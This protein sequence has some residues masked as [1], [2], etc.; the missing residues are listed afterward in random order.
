MKNYKKSQFL[1]NFIL[2]SLTTLI[3]CS[4]V[5]YSFLFPSINILFSVSIPNIPSF[6]FTAKFLFFL[7]NGI[8][9]ILIRESKQTAGSN[10]SPATEIYNE[11]V[12]RSR[13]SNYKPHFSYTLVNKKKV[14]K[15]E[16]L[17]TVDKTFHAEKKKAVKMCSGIPT[18]DLNGIVESKQAGS[19][20]CSSPVKGCRSYIAPAH[21]SYTI[22]NKKV[23]KDKISHAEKKKEVK[24]CSGIVKREKREKEEENY[25]P[26]EELNRRVE[27]YIARVKQRFV[28]MV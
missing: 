1:C 24:F 16:N 4:F 11:Y 10:S 6:F 21:S 22:A 7:G 27:A 28:S 8:V 2:Y 26:T 23:E 14:E 17:H 20:S 18:E 9:I 25:I 12:A 13:R 19:S 3:S 15:M 5:H